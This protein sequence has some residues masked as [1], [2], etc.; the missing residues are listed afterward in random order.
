V[1]HPKK[2]RKKKKKTFSPSPKQKLLIPSCTMIRKNPF[3]HHQN[4]EDMV[5]K[6]KKTTCNLVGLVVVALIDQ[7]S[8]LINLAL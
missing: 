7:S 1:L 4:H 8:S 6:R 2:K 3:L 5:K